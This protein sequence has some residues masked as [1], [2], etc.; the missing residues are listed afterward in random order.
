MFETSLTKLLRRGQSASEGDLLYVAKDNE[1]AHNALNEICKGLLKRIEA[2]EEYISTQIT[3]PSMIQYRPEGQEEY[4]TLK[5]NF[6]L[7][8][9]RLNNLEQI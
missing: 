5:G 2:L 6:D 7:I 4:L 9:Q 8:Y 1:I 3:H